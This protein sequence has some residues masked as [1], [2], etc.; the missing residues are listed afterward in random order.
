MVLALGALA[1]AVSTPAAAQRYS[2]GYKFLEAVK[3]SEG[4]EVI[5]ML[6]E[7][8]NNIVTARDV[9]SGDTAL[10]IVARRQDLEFLKY[11]TQKGADVDAE[12]KAGE[13]PMS[14]AVS[15]NWLEGVEYLIQRKAKLDFTN[16]TGETPL[17][18]AVHRRSPKLVEMLVKAG[19]DPDRNDNSGR[20][21]R[22]Y[23]K[24]D[25]RGSRILAAIEDNEKKKS[26][27]GAYGPDVR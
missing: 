18:L 3:K 16:S 26:S 5:D 9:T 10:H 8:N 14:I 13:T 23:A 21:A 25:T 27:A 11:L 24:L 4:Q 20:S 17:I 7:S 1:V 19:A 6:A 15:F 2:Q 22:D 12:N